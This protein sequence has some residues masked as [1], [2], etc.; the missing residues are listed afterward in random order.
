MGMEEKAYEEVG[1]NYRFFARWR[2]AAAAGDLV[3]LWGVVS[4]C[5]SAYEDARPILWLI[6][7]CASPFALVFWIFDVRTRDMYHAAIRAGANLEEDTK[8]FYSCVK[9]EVALPKATSTFMTL[10]QSFALNLLF[11]GT[12]LVLL[13]LAV[14]FFIY[15]R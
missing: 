9:R 4:L 3:F 6:P 2:H 12:F 14:G 15:V 8:G 5:I 7:L 1:Q 11:F 13:L 10:T